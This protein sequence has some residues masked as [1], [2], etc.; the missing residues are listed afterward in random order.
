[1]A[2][3]SEGTATQRVCVGAIAG[4]HG[5][6]GA[7]RIKSFTEQPATLADYADLTDDQ[8]RPVRLAVKQVRADVVIALSNSLRCALFGR[9]PYSSR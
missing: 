6:R 4:A 3:R 7:I 1:M 2:D 9:S 8:G 5:V